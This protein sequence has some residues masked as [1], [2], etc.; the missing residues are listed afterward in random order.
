[1]IHYSETPCVS[2]KLTYEFD[3]ELNMKHKRYNL[4]IN[5]VD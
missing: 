5:L 3:E 1:M 4:N 2:E